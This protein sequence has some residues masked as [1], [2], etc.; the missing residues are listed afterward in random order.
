MTMS[1]EIDAAANKALNAFYTDIAN[2]ACIYNGVD[3]YKEVDGPP[4]AYFDGKDKAYVY[5]MYAGKGDKPLSDK[6][7]E[8]W[9]RYNL[10]FACEGFKAP[11]VVWRIR[12]ENNSPTEDNIPHGLYM[13]FV[14]CEEFNLPDNLL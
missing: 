4:N 12:P 11:V 14:V 13:R 7:F 1:K 10:H 3:T 2:A 9:V 8:Q 5:Q 6:I